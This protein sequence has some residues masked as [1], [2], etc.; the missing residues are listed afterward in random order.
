MPVAIRVAPSSGTAAIGR[1]C[2]PPLSGRRVVPLPAAGATTASTMVPQASHCGHCP[3]QRGWLP[4]HS[5]Q[6]AATRVL[7]TPER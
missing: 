6:R 1:A 7:T 2:G 3:T 4:P 5:A